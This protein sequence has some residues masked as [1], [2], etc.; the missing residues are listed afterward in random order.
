MA[1]IEEMANFLLE[2]G[3]S[4]IEVDCA[5]QATEYKV[6]VHCT[7]RPIKD[8]QFGFANLPLILR[9]NVTFPF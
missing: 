4:D 2:M 7:I 8:I 9:G 1:S 6:S 3:F 5:L